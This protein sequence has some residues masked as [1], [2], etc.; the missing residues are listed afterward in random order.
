MKKI[1]L[2]TSLSSLAIIGTAVPI[3]ATSCSSS[4]SEYTVSGFNW[5]K[6]P[7]VGVTSTPTMWYISKGDQFIAS[8]DNC[9][10]VTNL[11]V[12][13]ATST[14]LGFQYNPL[15]QVG[16]IKPT[17][18]GAKTLALDFT[19]QD[20]TK[21]TASTKVIVASNYPWTVTAKDNCTATEE[22]KRVTITDVTK[23]A[24]LNISMGS[25]P[26]GA[27]YIVKATT[28]EGKEITL[29]LENGVLTIPEKTFTANSQEVLV[30]TITVKNGRSV[31]GSTLYLNITGPTGKYTTDNG[32]VTFSEWT[33]DEGSGLIDFA[34]N[35]HFQVEGIPEGGFNF[36]IDNS[37]AIANFINKYVTS[38]IVAEGVVNYIIAQMKQTLF[39][40]LSTTD[41]TIFKIKDA[42]VSW[43]TVDKELSLSSTF[44]FSFPEEDDSEEDKLNSAPEAPTDIT[45]STYGKIVKDEYGGIDKYTLTYYSSITV[46]TYTWESKNLPQVM[47]GANSYEYR[48]SDYPF[49]APFWEIMFLNNDS[50]PFYLPIPYSEFHDGK[51]FVSNRSMRLVTDGSEEIE[52]NKTVEE[53]A[54]NANFPMSSSWEG[55]TIDATKESKTLPANV[56]SLLS[57]ENTNIGI[58]ADG[59]AQQLAAAIKNRPLFEEGAEIF[60]CGADLY[61]YWAQ[62]EE[63]GGNAFFVSAYLKYVTKNSS[64][65]YTNI[66]WFVDITFKLDKSNNVTSIKVE[67]QDWPSTL[68]A[69]DPVPFIIS[70]TSKDIVA[71]AQTNSKDVTA[72]WDI[73]L[74]DWE[75]GSGDTEFKLHIPY[76][77]YGDKLTVK[78]DK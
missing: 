57:T 20:G 61:W 28:S 7:T 8:Y 26:S 29:K 67:N 45:I 70:D 3:V 78:V 65:L 11:E 76:T 19:L 54:S 33:N 63:N 64:G 72:G 25:I 17:A 41:V 59:V 46:E 1:K 51:D 40:S 15:T 27:E 9:E 47:F 49:D 6:V 14:D 12:N 71:M 34:E 31:L 18:E 60:M 10:N 50:I 62:K 30:C 37:K 75:R 21:F 38:G 39:R 77:D 66:N 55:L 2:L 36:A 56:T 68:K 52:F 23:P 48:F 22:G 44:I 58:L 42:F 13:S 16:Y 24:T 32:V 5:D 69:A 35:S 43:K 74:Q 4:S 73:T 53:Y